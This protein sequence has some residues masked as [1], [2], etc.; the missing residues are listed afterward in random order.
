MDNEHIGKVKHCLREP[1]VNPDEIEGALKMVRKV[2]SSGNRLY[3]RHARKAIHAGDVSAPYLFETSKKEDK[4]VEHALSRLK[5]IEKTRARHL[6]QKTVNQIYK[7]AKG[8][9]PRLK[10]YS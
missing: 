1:K 7:E 8:L 6:N 9:L 2:M 5:E 4:V 3:A 10:H